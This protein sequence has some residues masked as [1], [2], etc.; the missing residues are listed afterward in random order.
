CQQ[1]LPTLPSLVWLPASPIDQVADLRAKG[2]LI[3]ES[4]PFGRTFPT[5]H[6][7]TSDDTSLA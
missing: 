4:A 3:L 6:L 2:S 7:V 5:A 1:G